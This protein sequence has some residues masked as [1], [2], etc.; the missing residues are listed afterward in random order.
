[1]NGISFMSLRAA[2][3][4]IS[5]LVRSSGAEIASAPFDRLR[6][7]RNDRGGE[8]KGWQFRMGR[9]ADVGQ[10]TPLLFPL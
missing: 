6:T 10:P 5:T 3:E 2:G 4:A 1:M 9:L 7:P 8:I